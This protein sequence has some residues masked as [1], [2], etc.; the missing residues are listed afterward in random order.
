M[1]NKTIFIIL[2]L[3]AA[4]IFLSCRS[5][6]TRAQRTAYKTEKRMKKENEKLVND[7]LEH[8]YNIQPDETQMMIKNSRKRAKMINK[9]RKNS[10]VNRTFKRKR[11]KSCYGN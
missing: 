1:R 6:M 3:S 9:G 11:S 4:S 8:H 5:Q 10:F 2:L 7:Y